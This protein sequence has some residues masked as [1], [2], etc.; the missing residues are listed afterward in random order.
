MESKIIAAT[1][2]SPEV[3]FDLLNRCCSITGEAYPEDPAAFWGPI[4]HDMQEAIAFEQEKEITVDF[5]MA[6]FNSSSAK[7]LMNIFQLLE[8]VA[9]VGTKVKVNWYYQEGDDTM[10][11]SG[12]DFSEDLEFVDFHLIRLEA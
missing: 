8:S 3:K 11:E 9:A 2:R 4:L 10:L 6:Y 7:A 1:D 12:E 5:K